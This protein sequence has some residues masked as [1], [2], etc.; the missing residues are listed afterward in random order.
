MFF[1]R[2]VVE[3]RIAQAERLDALLDN[4]E[5]RAGPVG[6]TGMLRTVPLS[7]PGLVVDA[8][9]T[10]ARLQTMRAA[11]GAGATPPTTAAMALT[12]SLT[13]THA[14]GA[15]GGSAAPAWLNRAHG[16]HADGVGVAARGDAVRASMPD[17]LL[18][19]RAEAD[20]RLG[21][22][23]I[24]PWETWV[25]S[26]AHVAAVLA[27]P[28]H[29]DRGTLFAN[30]ATM[31]GPGEAVDD[32]DAEGAAAVV[33]GLY[34]VA[35]TRVFIPPAAQL[36][37]MQAREPERFTRLLQALDL[38]D[39]V[40]GGFLPVAGRQL[41]ALERARAG[42][43]L[44]E[45]RQVE[46]AAFFARVLPDRAIT[47]RLAVDARM[48]LV[49]VGDAVMAGA[50]HVGNR[51]AA[52]FH[53]GGTMQAPLRAPWWAMSPQQAADRIRAHVVARGKEETGDGASTT[54]VVAETPAVVVTENPADP[55]GFVLSVEVA[56]T[57]TS[58]GVNTAITATFSTQ[59]A[60][61]AIA[62]EVQ[63][64][65]A[66][67]TNL[68]S[69]T[70]SR[71][72]DGALLLVGD[73]RYV[74]QVQSMATARRVLGDAVE[75]YTTAPVVGDMAKETSRSDAVVHAQL[76]FIKLAAWVAAAQ[77]F[78]KVAGGGSIGAASVDVQAIANLDDL[79][80]NIAELKRLR[81]DGTTAANVAEAE[82]TRTALAKT[83]HDEEIA[84]QKNIC[85]N[86]SAAEKE[87]HT[88]QLKLLQEQLLQK[89]KEAYLLEPPRVYT[90]PDPQTFFSNAGDATVT[91]TTTKKDPRTAAHDA[92]MSA[93]SVNTASNPV[94]TDFQMVTAN[95]LFRRL[96]ATIA[97]M[98]C[99]TT[100]D[101]LQ[102]L[103]DTAQT[104]GEDFEIINNKYL[105]LVE[106]AGEVLSEDDQNLI[107]DFPDVLRT[108]AERLP[109]DKMLLDPINKL[110]SSDDDVQKLKND[111]DTRKNVVNLL[112][113]VQPLLGF[114]LQVATTV[115][116]VYKAL[117][118]ETLNMLRDDDDPQNKDWA[119]PEKQ[120]DVNNLL[121]LYYAK[122]HIIRVKEADVLNLPRVLVKIIPGVLGF[123]VGHSPEHLPSELILHFDFEKPSLTALLWFWNYTLTQM[124]KNFHPP[125]TFRAAFPTFVAMLAGETSNKADVLAKFERT[126]P[127]SGIMTSYI[128]GSKA[129]DE[130][131]IPTWVLKQPPKILVTPGGGGIPQPPSAPGV[132]PQPPSA[133]G[134]IP[135]PPVVNTKSDC[136]GLFVPTNNR[137]ETA[138]QI[139][140]MVACASLHLTA[141]VKLKNNKTWA[142]VDNDRSALQWV[143]LCVPFGVPFPTVTPLSLFTWH[144]NDPAYNNNFLPLRMPTT[145]PI[146]MEIW[147]RMTT[148]K[149][150]NVAKHVL[151]L[152]KTTLSET[153]SVTAASRITDVHKSVN[154]VVSNASKTLTPAARP[155][156]PAARPLLLPGE[157]TDLQVVGDHL[158]VDIIH[159]FYP[160]IILTG[161]R[162]AAMAVLNR[163]APWRKQTDLMSQRVHALFNYVMGLC[164]LDHHDGRTVQDTVKMPDASRLHK[165][166]TVYRR[167]TLRFIESFGTMLA[168]I[169]KNVP[170]T[171]AD[172]VPSI[173]QSTALAIDLTVALLQIVV[174]GERSFNTMRYVSFF[175]GSYITIGRILLKCTQLGMTAAQYV[176]HNVHMFLLFEDQLP[177]RG[178]SGE[179]KITNLN[180]FEATFAAAV[181]PNSTSQTIVNTNMQKELFDAPAASIYAN[182]RKLMDI[183]LLSKT[184]NHTLNFVSGQHVQDVPHGVMTP[185]DMV[186]FSAF[187]Y[188]QTKQMV[189]VWGML[190]IGGKLTWPFPA[191][192]PNVFT[193][194][195]GNIL[196]CGEK[197]EETGPH[198]WD[199]F[200]PSIV[201][202]SGMLPADTDRV[203]TIAM[204]FAT[205][206]TLKLTLS[207]DADSFA[208]DHNLA[209]VKFEKR[210]QNT[211]EDLQTAVKTLLTS[212]RDSGNVGWSRNNGFTEPWK[213]LQLS[214]LLAAHEPIVLEVAAA[215][216]IA[217]K[218]DKFTLWYDKFVQ[219][220]QIGVEKGAEKGAYEMKAVAHSLFLANFT[221]QGRDALEKVR[222]SE[223][224]DNA[225]LK[226]DKLLIPSFANDASVCAA[227]MPQAIISVFLA[228]IANEKPE[229]FSDLSGTPVSKN[230]ETNVPGDIGRGLHLRAQSYLKR[231]QP[232]SADSTAVQD[233]IN[234]WEAFAT[235]YVQTALD[236]KDLESLVSFLKTTTMQNNITA[237]AFLDLDVGNSAK[238]QALVDTHMKLAVHIW[239]RI[240]I[241]QYGD[242]DNSRKIGMHLLL[243]SLEA[244]NTDNAKTS[245]HVTNVI[246]FLTSI[247]LRT[248]FQPEASSEHVL[249]QMHVQSNMTFKVDPPNT[250]LQRVF[251]DK[252]TANATA[253]LPDLVLDLI[254][255]IPETVERLREDFPEGVQMIEDVVT[256]NKSALG[257]ETAVSTVMKTLL[258]MDNE[259]Y[260]L[261][262]L[263]ATHIE[264]YK[265]EEHDANTND[266]LHLM[267]WINTTLSKCLLI[268]A[269]KLITI[270]CPP[271]LMMLMM[272]GVHVVVHNLRDSNANVR[273]AYNQWYERAHGVIFGKFPNDD[274]DI[275][276]K[277]SQLMDTMAIYNTI[278]MVANGTRKLPVSDNDLQLAHHLMFVLGS[279]GYSNSVGKFRDA[280]Q[281]DESRSENN[282]VFASTKKV[283]SLM[284][285]KDSLWMTENKPA[286][287]KSSEQTM[288]ESIALRNPTNRVD[289]DDDD[290]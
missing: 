188:A 109:L 138:Q 229:E 289:D 282:S 249:H 100:Q 285:N 207:L 209:A 232:F 21:A 199:T 94:R 221:V 264:D 250:A 198:F 177:S 20:V 104:I 9:T 116:T 112:A 148:S 52:M 4:H 156:L 106:G 71:D 256:A 197:V 51:G 99:K 180:T 260:N 226:V 175:N 240:T 16:V 29:A 176:R 158:L 259:N 147:N 126:V 27:D 48:Q 60:R 184:T 149:E 12:V 274:G 212:V 36:A 238:G 123:V 28:A 189:R 68:V 72:G 49:S 151:I 34:D 134:G 178:S 6:A 108:F 167:A 15:A 41:A 105:R 115:Q 142:K 271:Q 89:E 277:T 287:P 169:R 14:L 25:P 66:H 45:R 40:A 219:T 272:L 203:V 239:D 113:K 69:K 166:V 23:A 145:L 65:V 179:L 110:F 38:Q 64:A 233:V 98:V 165:M 205:A 258:S 236:N 139:L 132:I 234:T 33:A 102:G 172:K 254:M 78:R 163:L 136:S 275:N 210:N 59:E 245:K 86:M 225:L 281:D 280:I 8:S 265:T 162:N 278:P 267:N 111:R 26:R 120:G 62:T 244:E 11:G 74:E 50:A 196:T 73:N 128:A 83:N 286:E 101:L 261:E 97:F 119:I 7:V 135:Q 107:D 87:S 190:E 248:M 19:T 117:Q 91:A 37:R 141:A 85:T 208:E 130:K 182:L 81:L 213:L 217:G 273:P 202:A 137:Q 269:P 5:L 241:N 121:L 220:S 22:W 17:G 56:D 43:V 174:E 84:R 31:L 114:N 230:P 61:D 55:G 122:K 195:D 75:A 191:I 242:L 79:K 262:A 160:A 192:D 290:E 255:S 251:P 173:M 129:A 39:T 57:A 80:A 204:T 70:D 194:K 146:V 131:L 223:M 3:A 224:A 88:L 159:T 144:V 270:E 231:Q 77:A 164:M 154:S 253:N 247:S 32:D 46:A 82:K 96:T 125:G 155:L 63:D 235:K 279:E 187:M 44:P 67:V 206:T 283:G 185:Q 181:T 222:S 168:D 53:G 76:A 201:A 171:D 266:V 10:A 124:V 257:V 24:V 103:V 288:L 140:D 35:R 47:D 211:P 90:V 54:V 186:A 92:A 284:G 1:R 183:P 30:L 276:L 243:T 161:D 2:G 118:T 215:A 58:T 157:D 18:M 42:I 93:M 193:V 214:D 268:F 228:S 263:L 153:R 170:T 216:T 252:I 227:I 133:P 95:D 200:S 218:Y 127:K 246:A 152:L 13:A 237:A 150:S 143:P